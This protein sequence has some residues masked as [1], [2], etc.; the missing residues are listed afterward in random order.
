[1]E[2]VAVNSQEKDFKQ[3]SAELSLSTAKCEPGAGKRC[4][5]SKSRKMNT[6]N[7]TTV[8]R[9]APSYQM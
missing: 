4:R 1:M 6:F 8:Q 9:K 2:G 5:E 3:D 7:G